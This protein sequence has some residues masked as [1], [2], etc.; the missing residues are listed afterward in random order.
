MSIGQIMKVIDYFGP[1]VAKT[2]L[3]SNDT[4][5]L[6]EICQQSFQSCSHTLVGFIKEEIFITD[7]LRTS[8]VY[9][10]IINK[11]EEYLLT[12]DSGLWDKVLKSGDIEHPLELKTA[13]YNKQVSMEYNPMHN[14]AYACDLVCV[15]FPKITLDNNVKDYYINNIN[16]RQT[17]QLN[18]VFGESPVSG[19]GINKIT[20]QP[21]EGDMYI[22][23]SYLNHFTT[24]VLGNSIRYSVGC[25]FSFTGL[26]H[27]LSRKFINYEN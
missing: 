10:T 23:P 5:L 24:P 26:V 12:V 17:G 2:T 8:P 20:V 11:V 1:R 3:S 22:F 7:Q 15:I 21:E 13:W 9:N 19:L 18:F 14:H 27:R 6:F 4:N 25:N 16:E